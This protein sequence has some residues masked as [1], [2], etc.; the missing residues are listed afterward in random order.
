MKRDQKG[1][2]KGSERDQKGPNGTKKARR[3][4]KKNEY[5][6]HL[7]MNDKLS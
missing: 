7:H 1:I 4:Q 3:K 5:E 6:I 2:R